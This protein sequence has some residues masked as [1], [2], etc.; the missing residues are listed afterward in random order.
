MGTNVA[1]LVPV[2]EGYLSQPAGPGLPH[3]GLSV[4]HWQPWDPP[5]PGAVA[6]LMRG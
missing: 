4:P 3:F 2:L 5:G 6:R 1:L